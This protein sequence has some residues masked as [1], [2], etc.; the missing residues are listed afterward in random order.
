MR[1][2]SQAATFNLQDLDHPHDIPSTTRR[3][4]PHRMRC[5]LIVWLQDFYHFD[6][7]FAWSP[8]G[9][10]KATRQDME[11]GSPG[12]T[13]LLG[14]A[15]Q[16]E[17]RIVGVRPSPS[18]AVLFLGSEELSLDPATD[19]V[20]VR[21]ADAQVSVDVL[22]HGGLGALTVASFQYAATPEEFD[23]WEGRAY[24]LFDWLAERLQRPDFQSSFTQRDR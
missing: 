11:A 13:H 6:T 18:G 12:P 4:P 3:G 2:V 23:S 8:H 10:R 16:F 14:R 20:R 1:D 24:G 17:D 9:L 15:A 5:P 19:E 21:R 22:R 7:V